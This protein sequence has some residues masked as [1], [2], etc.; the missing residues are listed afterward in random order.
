MTELTFFRCELCGRVVS[1]WDIPKGGCQACGCNRVRPTNLTWL[2]K[3]VQVARHPKIW[4][5]GD[6]VKYQPAEEGECN[7]SSS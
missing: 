5:W 3:I 4:T 7:E 2:E 1:P 6:V